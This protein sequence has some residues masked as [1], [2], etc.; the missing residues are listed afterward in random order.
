MC[1]RFTLRTPA[2]DVAKQFGLLEVPPF[3]PRFNVAPSQPVAAVRQTPG[4]SAPRRQWAWLRWGLV[5]SW[6]KD[7]GVG[8][9]LI[10]ARAETAAEKPAFRAALRRRRCLVAADGFYEWQHTGQRKQPFYFHLRDQ[11]PFGFAGLWETWQGPEASPI[12]TCTVL[13]TEANE[14]VRPIH[15]R[16]PVIVAP[17][18]YDLWLDPAV[19]EPA[20]LSRLWGPYPAG[21]M[22]AYPVSTRI[23]SPANEDPRCIE[24]LG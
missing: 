7:P 1:G 2:S 15:D 23:N 16:M 4:E 21:E 12:E 13:T 19:E 22:A 9:R 8:N 17:A 3:E 10:N 18:D 20:E 24:P 6:A 14:L 11:R 5:P